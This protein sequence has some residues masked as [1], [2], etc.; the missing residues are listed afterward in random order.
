M[1]DDSDIE[2][3]LSDKRLEEAII[4]TG[5]KLVVLDPIQGI[6]TAC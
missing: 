1:I 6:T 3:T 2:L 4:E 5:A